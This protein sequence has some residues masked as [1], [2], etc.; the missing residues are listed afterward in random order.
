ME[1]ARIR[2]FLGDAVVSLEEVGLRGRTSSGEVGGRSPQQC[3]I[4]GRH[5]RPDPV[6]PADSDRAGRPRAVAAVSEGRPHRI[7][8]M[9]GDRRRADTEASFV[10]ALVATIQYRIPTPIEAATAMAG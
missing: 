10:I 7:R 6:A 5:R 3:S 2:R 1:Q 9:R 4:P 8:A